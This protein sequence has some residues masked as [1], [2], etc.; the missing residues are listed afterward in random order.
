MTYEEMSTLPVKASSE[1]VW[2]IV[3]RMTGEGRVTWSLT[4]GRWRAAWTWGDK[5]T[6]GTGFIDDTGF[7]YVERNRT[8]ALLTPY[9]ADKQATAGLFET[10]IAQQIGVASTPCPPLENPES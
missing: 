2:R 9:P 3:E 8:Y 10:L 5:A 4:G 6:G 1:A 7:R